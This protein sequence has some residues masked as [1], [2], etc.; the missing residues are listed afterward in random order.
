MSKKTYKLYH[1]HKISNI[2]LYVFV[3]SPF[4]FYKFEIGTQDP[5]LSYFKHLAKLP[6]NLTSSHNESNIC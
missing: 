4:M 6:M 1:P 3:H 2:M 5:F